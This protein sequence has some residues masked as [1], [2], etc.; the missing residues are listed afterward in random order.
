MEIILS[1]TST[2]LF[3]ALIYTKYRK[4]NNGVP[5]INIESVKGQD[6]EIRM[7]M[8]QAYKIINAQI[9]FEA[10]RFAMD[11]EK[12][13]RKEATI[14]RGVK[15]IEGGPDFMESYTYIEGKTEKIILTV[16]WQHNTFQ[17]VINETR[18]QRRKN[19]RMEIVKS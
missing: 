5:V 4:H 3:L 10:G 19:E 2:L 18:N 8:K 12:V 16:V 7:W 17:I 13:K 15:L 11:L 14:K 9:E 6:N 1:V